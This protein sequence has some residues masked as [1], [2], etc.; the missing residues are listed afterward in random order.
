MINKCE[1]LFVGLGGVLFYL[2]IGAFMTIAGCSDK[3]NNHR[4]CD[5]PRIRIE[6]AFPG[7]QFGCWLGGVPE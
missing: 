2:L 5:E 3:K 7:Y 6:Y 4:S 1:V